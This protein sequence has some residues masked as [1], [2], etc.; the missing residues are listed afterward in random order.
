MKLCI[1][2]GFLVLASLV[3]AQKTPKTEILRPV[4][5]T[6]APIVPKENEVWLNLQVRSH[7]DVT[8]W[9][10]TSEKQA[11]PIMGPKLL[12][13]NFSFSFI[14]TDGAMSSVRGKFDGDKFD[15]WMRLDGYDT[16]ISARRTSTAPRKA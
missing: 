12:G 15:G 5:V 10:Q 7:P 3:Q 11:A 2:A 9:L 13:N 8:Y 14:N 6:A 1:T 4:S 16:P